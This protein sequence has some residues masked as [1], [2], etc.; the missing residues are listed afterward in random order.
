M[1]QVLAPAGLGHADVQVEGYVS[2]V[3]ELQ[4][5]LA[6]P[7]G[8]EVVEP[9]LARH[10][11]PV[12]HLH[13]EVPVGLQLR[14]QTVILAGDL[15]P[16]LEPLVAQGLVGPLDPRLHRGLA[17]G[18]HRGLHIVEPLEPVEALEGYQGQVHRLFQVAGVVDDELQALALAVGHLDAG[19]ALLHGQTVAGRHPEIQG[20]VVG[21]PVVKKGQ[22]QVS[23]GTGQGG[24]VGGDLQAEGPLD[25]RSQ[26][27]IHLQVHRLGLP[28]GRQFR[29]GL[30][31]QGRLVAQVGHVELD[32]IAPLRH[33]VHSLTGPLQFQAVVGAHC[34][35]VL[36]HK[37]RFMSNLVQQN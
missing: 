26:R 29:Q 28:A 19:F 33:Q 7:P 14:G 24:S 20:Q 5:G 18:G 22:V 15:E 13:D 21:G 32:D 37:V 30:V 1:G 25:P 23:G 27:L 34:D 11:G 9:Q 16:A 2:V 8:L 4:V 6:Q 36:E 3:G 12:G 35:L 10:A 17:E 31:E